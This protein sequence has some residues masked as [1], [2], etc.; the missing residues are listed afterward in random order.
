MA[1]RLGANGEEKPL[2]FIM[3]DWRVIPGKV[4]RA[5]CLGYATAA[6]MAGVSFIVVA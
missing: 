4:S 6:E 2:L 3:R 1:D 5:A